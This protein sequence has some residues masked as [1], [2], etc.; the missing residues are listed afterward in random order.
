MHKYVRAPI[1]M[2]SSSVSQLFYIEAS[3]AINTGDV[4]LPYVKKT[5]KTTFYFALPFCLFLMFFGPFFFKTYLGN[6]WEEAGYYARNITPM[7]FLSFLTSPISSIPILMHKQKQAF[8]MS[9]FGYTLSAVSLLI[10][11]QFD[12]SFANSLWF[13]CAGFCIYYGLLLTW[14]LK[15]ARTLL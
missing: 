7:L 11:I 1:G 15:L 12:L 13:Y 10:A 2:I 8:L 5:M 4:I 3:K 14:Y 9:V 6:E